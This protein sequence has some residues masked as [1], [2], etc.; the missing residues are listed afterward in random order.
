MLVEIVHDDIISDVA[1]G[2]REVA[3]GPETLSPI[4]LSDVLELLL[5][6]SRGAPFRHTHKVADRDVGWDLDEHVDV[7]L[8]QRP[9][10]DRDAHLC[11]Y[12]LDDIAHSKPDFAMEHLEPIFWCPDDMVTVVENR[13]TAGAIAHSLYPR[14]K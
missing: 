1:A 7:V 5:D 8:R 6:F 3:S 4:A 10:H 9:I 11:A 2:C 13:V 14:K 12:L